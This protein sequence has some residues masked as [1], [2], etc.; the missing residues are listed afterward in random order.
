ME[1]IGKSSGDIEYVAGIR[2]LERSM[3]GSSL[4]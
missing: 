1:G 4:D 3:R 2:I